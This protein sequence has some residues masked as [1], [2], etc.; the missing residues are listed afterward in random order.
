MKLFKVLQMIDKELDEAQSKFKP[1]NSAH[2]GYA[3]I[4]EELDELW[5]EIKHNPKDWKRIQEETVQVATTAIRFL[6]D[7]TQR[8]EIKNG[9]TKTNILK[10]KKTTLPQIW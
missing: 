4:K 5:D 9:N 10:T 1:Y 7:L 2:E 6:T 8:V 3:V